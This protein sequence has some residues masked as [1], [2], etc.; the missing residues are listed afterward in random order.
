MATWE[1]LRDILEED[2]AD[3]LGT[4]TLRTA[5]GTVTVPAVHCWPPQLANDRRVTGLE[6][7]IQK[8]PQISQLRC[9]REVARTGTYT[10]R[11]VQHD[12]SRTLTEAIERVLS[13]FPNARATSIAGT[14]LAE[15]QAT[16][17]IPDGFS[18][19]VLERPL[20]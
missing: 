4:Y 13:R 15:E 19:V 1:D 7:L 2:L 9:Y 16:I 10:V 5:T 12:E 14:D 8:N 3:L 17:A 11:L 20:F 6:L 18:R